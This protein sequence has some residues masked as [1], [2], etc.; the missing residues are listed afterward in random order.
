MASTLVALVCPLSPQRHSLS[1]LADHSRRFPYCWSSRRSLPPHPFDTGTACPPAESHTPALHTD[2][3]QSEEFKI[4][5]SRTSNVTRHKSKEL[6]YIHPLKD[7]SLYSNLFTSLS[8]R[9]KQ[10]S[11]PGMTCPTSWT[12]R[13]ESFSSVSTRIT[14]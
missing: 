14:P 6:I 9:V 7:P 12:V 5:N 8:V 10:I 3:R 1:F 4:Q 2:M 13:T 11:P